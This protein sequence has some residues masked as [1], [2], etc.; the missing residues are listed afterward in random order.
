MTAK[1]A[2]M[3]VGGLRRPPRSS[4][5]GHARLCSP[6]R[7]NPGSGRGNPGLATCL[8]PGLLLGNNRPHHLGSIREK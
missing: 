6:S 8:S 4:R 5:Y 3:S 7:R 1:T 2:E